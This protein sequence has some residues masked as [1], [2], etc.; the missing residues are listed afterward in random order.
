MEV[1]KRHSA[2]AD[3]MKDLGDFSSLPSIDAIRQKQLEACSL[4]IYPPHWRDLCFV[5]EKL[6]LYSSLKDY[7]D[8][9]LENLAQFADY[10][11]LPKHWSMAARQEIAAREGLYT[12]PTL[13]P[14]YKH[15]VQ[16]MHKL[17]KQFSGAVNGYDDVHIN[18]LVAFGVIEADSALSDKKAVDDAWWTQGLV[19]RFP[20]IFSLLNDTK[21]YALLQGAIY[22]G[23]I[24]FLK[25]ILHASNTNFA[26]LEDYWPFAAASGNI[27]MLEFFQLLVPVPP[28]LG[29]ENEILLYCGLLTTTTACAADCGHLHALQWLKRN[30]F[31]LGITAC[32]AAAEGGHLEVLK[33]LHEQGCPW[34][35]YTCTTAAVHGNL[36]ILQYL[37]E[38]GCPWDAGTCDAAA[39]GGHLHILQW[40]R[41][42][43]CPW[44]ENIC[45]TAAWEKHWDVLKWAIDNGCAC[46]AS[47]LEDAKKNGYKY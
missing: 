32:T 45:R 4:I 46:D 16:E 34:D 25:L 18:E 37:R 42:N 21:Q 30:G 12:H 7:K 39:E 44:D 9:E 3:V 20:H 41:A 6:S 13:E 38:N 15:T 40:A 47:I 2:L 29:D 11:A 28:P 8:E 14:I 23:N 43:G 22:G 17:A 5:K 36:N 33:W 31:T 1:F 19:G 26:E 27:Q 10:W 35:K 24:D